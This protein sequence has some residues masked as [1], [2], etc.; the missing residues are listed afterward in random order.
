MIGRQLGGYRIESEIGRGGMG[1]VYLAEQVRLERRVALKVISPELAHDAAFRTRFER[2]SRVAASIDHPNVVPIYEAGEAEGLL[3]LA[4]RHV[5]GSDLKAALAHGPLEPGRAIAIVGQIAS[6]L[7]AAHARGLVHRDVKPG[8]VLIE[9]APPRERAYLTDFGL[10]KRLSSTSGIT[11]TGFVV[12][13]L[14]YI[15]PEQVEGATIDAR[16]DV[17]ALAC[18]LFH[19]LSGRVPFERENDMAKMYAHAK[20]EAPPLLEVVPALPRALDEV[21]RRGMAKDPAE[22]FASAGDLGRAAEAA[23]H[24]GSPTVAERSVAIGAAAPGGST[25][26]ETPLPGPPAGPPVPG[27]PPTAETQP[28]PAVAPPPAPPSPVRPAPPQPA[29]AAAPPPHPVYQPPPPPERSGDGTRTALIATAVMLALIVGVAVALLATGALGGGDD[30]EGGEPAT[31]TEARTTETV[32]EERT[33][34]TT[35]ETTT[36]TTP[37]DDGP[38]DF[39]YGPLN[40][41]AASF[42]TVVPTGDGWSEPDVSELAGGEILRTRLTGPDGLEIIIDHTPNEAATF[43]P[44]E[45]CEETQHPTVQYTARCVFTGGTLE[46]CK[47]SRCIDYLLN[48]FEDGPGWAV[49]VGGGDF[50]DTE[51]ISKRVVAAFEPQGLGGP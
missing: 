1:V 48:A 19:T 9:G 40:S 8:N 22:R 6:A 47:R 35:P 21:V 4:M 20:V 51:A 27:E 13:T 36:E 44:P 14:D 46:P 18:V 41:E 50:A 49:V 3:Y 25:V 38:T 33:T 26:A 32:T 10:T 42:R 37:P 11:A 16:T 28:L 5:P 2:E 34:E 39:D 29:R 45:R 31:S 23:V 7:D 15:A 30:E 17:Y 24:G 12:G 43:K